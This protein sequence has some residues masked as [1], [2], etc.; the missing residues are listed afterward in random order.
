MTDNVTGAVL[1]EQSFDA[2]GNLTVQTN[3]SNLDRYGYAGY[4]WMAT[5]GLYKAGA[6]DYN[7]AVGRWMEVD[8]SGFDAGDSNLYRYAGN[9]PT[10]ATDPSGLQTDAK[11][12]ARQAALQLP[13]IQW[14]EKSAL[15][16]LNGT[17]KVWKSERMYFA[18]NLLEH[19]IK[20]KGKTPYIPTEKDK[21]EVSRRSDAAVRWVLENVRF[22]APGNRFSYK[23]R[24][25]WWASRTAFLVGGLTSKEVNFIEKGLFYAYAGAD[26][27]LTG[28]LKN[29]KAEGKS[30]TFD[31]E[32]KVTFTDNWD[33]PPSKVRELFPDYQAALYLQHD[34]AT[35]YAV[36]THTLTFTRTYRN[37]R[38][39]PELNRA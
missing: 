10:D 3:A 21:D 7:P 39:A 18:A 30:Y 33:F 16:Q 19:W 2:Y 31:A 28:V 29:V 36:F 9:G 32:V 25:R 15:R 12:R 13:P 37:L 26:I 34:K 38:K 24:V 27:Q 8:P 6:R 14:N 22:E 23:G 1:A 4:Q 20:T 11:I 35:K 5:P 17:I